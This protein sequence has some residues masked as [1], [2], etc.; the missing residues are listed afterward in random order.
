MKNPKT[1][2]MAACLLYFSSAAAQDK[3]VI[4][5][6]T[7]LPYEGPIILYHR[8][9]SL[10]AIISRSSFIIEGS[11]DHPKW[12]TLTI[13]GSHCGS[14]LFLD[15]SNIE[16]SVRIEKDPKST[17]A[18]IK[19]VQGSVSDSLVRTFNAKR[20][21]KGT[22]MPKPQEVK[23][24]VTEFIREHPNFNYSAE[25]IYDYLTFYGRE[26]AK[27]M[28]ALLQPSALETDQGR[29]LTKVINAEQS[30]KKGNPFGAFSMKDT[31]GNWFHSASIQGKYVLYEFWAS[32]C[33]P[34]RKENP[35]IVA[36]Y[37]KYHS[38]GFEI[39]GI[40][41]DDKQTAWLD[42]IKKDKLPW[43]QVSDLQGWNNELS[44]R[45]FLTSIPFN[46]LVDP[47]GKIVA[48]NLRGDELN[49]KLSH[50]FKQ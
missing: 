26:W 32:W 29:L 42:A 44:K 10:T 33:G 36:N 43:I 20:L 50:I 5:G 46:I 27:E 7:D 40:S 24:I 49:R 47:S 38:K 22:T 34:C 48:T 37:N 17:C 31:A 30:N 4:H 21:P 39:V 1:F 18:F 9:D 28:H 41:L 12:Y 3:F 35:N 16:L 15:N 13:P 25:L 23:K 2:L 19:K 8:Q 14:R 6:N 45:H 11:V